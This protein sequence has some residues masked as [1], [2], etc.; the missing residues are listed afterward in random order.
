MKKFILVFLLLVG[1]LFSE[2]ANENAFACYNDKDFELFLFYLEKE[3]TQSIVKQIQDGDCTRIEA[4]TKIKVLLQE[5]SI[6][7]VDVSGIKMFMLMVGA[8]K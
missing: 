5:G 4:G 1:S 7:Y 6:A 2:T 3:Q 8:D